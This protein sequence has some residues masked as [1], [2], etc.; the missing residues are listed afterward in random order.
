MPTTTTA[1]TPNSTAGGPR[2]ARPSG[3]HSSTRLEVAQPPRILRTSD[4]IRYISGKSPDFWVNAT[5]PYGLCNV[6]STE[7]QFAPVTNLS[8]AC[9]QR[10]RKVS[11]LYH[12]LVEY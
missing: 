9:A 7:T 8:Q 5:N 12:K 4:Q 10:V 2:R 3:F 11:K 6:I 1:L